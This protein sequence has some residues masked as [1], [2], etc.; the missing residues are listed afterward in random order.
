MSPCH[1]DGG[2]RYEGVSYDAHTLVK[3]DVRGDTE[4]IFV[5]TKKGAN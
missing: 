4:H 3:S 5:S 1:G 2:V